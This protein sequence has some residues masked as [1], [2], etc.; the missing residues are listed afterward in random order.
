MGTFTADTPYRN[1]IFDSFCFTVNLQNIY[2]YACH[3]SH[4]IEAHQ[5]HVR[6]P[7]RRYR[8]LKANNDQHPPSYKQLPLSR[9]GILLN[10]WGIWDVF[11]PTLQAFKSLLSSEW[12]IINHHCDPHNTEWCG[13]ASRE[14]IVLRNLS[15]SFHYLIHEVEGETIML[16]HILTRTMEAY[17]P[18]F[19]CCKK[20]TRRIYAIVWGYCNGKIQFLLM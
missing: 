1:F 9:T 17:V 8:L 11:V 4:T 10:G 14:Q 12:A 15:A 16:W 20:W 6:H 18:L 7:S 19:M 13:L 2:N 5:Q 3:G